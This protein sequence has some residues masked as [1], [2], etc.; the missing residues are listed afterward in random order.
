M[1][2]PTSSL[3]HPP[4]G[5]DSFPPFFIMIVVISSGRAG[6]REKRKEGGV[7]NCEKGDPEDLVTSKTLSLTSSFLFPLSRFRVKSG[8]EGA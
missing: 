1:F 7:V 2:P 6:E 3:L 8:G 5:I 4:W